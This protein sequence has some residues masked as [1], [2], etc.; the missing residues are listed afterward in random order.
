MRISLLTAGAVLALLVL[1]AC[2]QR[3]DQVGVGAAPETTTVVISTSSAPPPEV[4]GPVPAPPQVSVDPTGVAVPP[5]LRELPP[6][7]VDAKGL[8]ATYTDR[9]VWV[10]ADGTVLELIAVAM[11]SCAGV[12]GR[13]VEATA[14][15]VRVALS[16]MAQTQGGPEG[17][18]CATVLTPRPISVPLGE[19]LGKRTVVIV[20]GP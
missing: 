11:D 18:I 4:S 13:V 9:R 7:Q 10:S 5:G 20:E 8:P 6:T 12:E 1:T 14:S 16:P 15:A 3:A 2:G 17:Q 19:P